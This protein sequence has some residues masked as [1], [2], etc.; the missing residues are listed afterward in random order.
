MD[1]N[2]DVALIDFS[3]GKFKRALRYVLGAGT[4]ALADACNTAIVIQHELKNIIGRSL[5]I[6]ILTDSETFFNAIIRNA[7]T[8]KR[9]LIIDVKAAR[10]AYNCVIVEDV[11]WIRRNYILE[12]AMTKT[13]MLPQLI[14]L[15]KTGK[16][17]YV[18]E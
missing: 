10:E 9:R 5:K 4:F 11:I 8:I 12:D 7:S 1:K 17:E 14:G 2:N 16:I 6:K 15:T 18:I 13:C 3:S